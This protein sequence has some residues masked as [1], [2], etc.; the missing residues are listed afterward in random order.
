M[1]NDRAMIDELTNGSKDLHSLT[2]RLVFDEIPNDYPVKDIKR[3]YHELR[4]LAK[5][6]EFC[7]NYSGDDSTLV[8]NYGISSERAK[9][10]YDSYMSGFSGLAAYQKFRKHDW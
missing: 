10:I 2:A 3:N 8:K 5:G 9:Q 6:Y 1:S 7:F 4:Q